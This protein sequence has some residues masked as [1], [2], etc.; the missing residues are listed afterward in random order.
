MML[1]AERLREVLTYCPDTGC[2]RWK[3]R[4]G[5]RAAVGAVAGTRT[6]AGY[7]QIRID[8]KYYKAHRLAVLYMT[9]ACPAGDVKCLTGTRSDDRWCNLRTEPVPLCVGQS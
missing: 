8:G 7:T 4:M 9:G 2:F 6:R 5:S 3:V 1:T